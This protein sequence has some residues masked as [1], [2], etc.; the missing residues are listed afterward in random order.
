MGGRGKGWGR[1]EG[2]ERTG[3]RGDRAEPGCSSHLTHPAPSVQGAVGARNP[4][5]AG[6]G[7]QRKQRPQWTSGRGGCVTVWNERTAVSRYE[8]ERRPVIAFVFWT[9]IRRIINVI[10]Y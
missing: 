8:R 9:L 5:A 6:S 2:K 7:T 4:G 3:R 10:I 1:T